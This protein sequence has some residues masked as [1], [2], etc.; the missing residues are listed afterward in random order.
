[1][2]SKYLPYKFDSRYEYRTY[3]NIGKDEAIKYKAQKSV[4]YNILWK[5]RRLLNHDD[6]NYRQL[7][8]Y[9]EWKIYI[10]EKNVNYMGNEDFIHFLGSK[11]RRNE[12]LHSVQGNIVTPIYVVMVS[13]GLS[14]L[15]LPFQKKYIMEGALYVWL[16]FCILVIFVLV[17]LLCCSYKQCNRH[18]FYRDYI[19]IIRGEE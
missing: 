14:L 11:A 4:Y 5:L 19:E 6:K 9:S 2:R 8:N 3:K 16:S 13:G 10:L 17:F 12:H 1:M 18:Y 15:L 7:K